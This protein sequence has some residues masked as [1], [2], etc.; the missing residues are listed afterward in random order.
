MKSFESSFFNCLN[1][2]Y[3]HESETNNFILLGFN[4]LPILVFAANYQLLEPSIILDKGGQQPGTYAGTGETYGLKEYL[5]TAYI[6]MFVLVITA[7]VFWLILGGLEYILSD[8]PMVKSSGLK[9]LKNAFF[10]LVIA[11]S[12]YLLLNLI[13]PKL[14][15]FNLKLTP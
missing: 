15:E 4:L 3:F 1:K 11:L 5:Q 7:V 6:V 9:K 13:N 8:I 10:G 2:S 14:L 12:S